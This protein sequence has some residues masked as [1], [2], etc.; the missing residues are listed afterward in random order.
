MKI[1]GKECLLIGGKEMATYILFGNYTQ[2]SINDISADRTNQTKSLIEKNGGKLEAG[3]A[4]LGDVDLI[5][6]VDFPDA[7]HAMKTSVALSKLLGVG[8]STHPAVTI[9]AFDKLTADI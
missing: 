8:F 3:Y 1:R 5:L 9:A 6:I 7:D 4:L 2:A